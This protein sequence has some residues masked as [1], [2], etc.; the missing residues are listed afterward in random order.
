MTT[1]INMYRNEFLFAQAYLEKLLLDKYDKDELNALTQTIKEWR[2]YE[3]SGSASELLDSFVGPVLDSLQF[4]RQ[5][6]QSILGGAQLLPH[7]GAEQPVGVVLVVDPTSQITCTSKGLHWAVKL[8]RFMCSTGAGWG[9]L[10]DGETWRLYRK[11]ELAPY[12]TFLEVSLGAAIDKDNTNA[13]R[14]FHRFFTAEAFTVLDDNQPALETYR[15]ASIKVTQEIEK[16]L[17]SSMD[18]VLRNISMGFVQNEARTSFSQEERDEIFQNSVYLLYR[19][20]FILYTES[21][22]LLPVSNPIYQ[23]QYSLK[24]LTRVAIGHHFKRSADITGYDLWIRLRKLFIWIDEGHRATPE[25]DFEITEYDG[26]LFDTSKRPYLSEHL[27]NNEFLSE[28]LYQ[29]NCMD[30]PKKP[31]EHRWIDYRDL[32]VRHLGSLYES[33][34]EYKLYI[35]EQPMVASV[36]GDK[37]KYELQSSVQLKETDQGNLIPRG[38]VY[39]GQSAT[40]RKRTG[41]YYTP[42]DVVEYI[43][44]NTVSIG[45]ENL[46]MQ[47]QPELSNLQANVNNS[48]SDAERLRLQRYTDETVEQFI[49]Q[50]VFT[51]R[52]LDPAMGSGHFLVNAL[53]K[54]TNFAVDKLSETP[55]PN[56]ALDTSPV[57]W[58]RRVV[59]RCIFGVDLN[60]LA[61]ELAKLSLWLASASEG[62]PLSFLN[63]HLKTGNSLIGAKLSDLRALP[64]ANDNK[65][66]PTLPF[67]VDDTL[68]LVISEYNKISAHDSDAM[69]AVEDK[70]RRDKQIGQILTRIKD[71]ANVWV[72]TFYGNQVSQEQYS[73]LL[74][75]VN[76]NY[77]SD[78]WEYVATSKPYISKARD[79]ASSLRFFHWDLEFAEAFDQSSVQFD[80]VIANPPYVGTRAD[81]Y[82]LKRYTTSGCGDLYAWI[83]ERTGEIISARG[84][85]GTVVPLSV[86]FSRQMRP[87]RSVFLSWKANCYLSSYDIRPASLFGTP[88]S[89]NSQRATIAI[90]QNCGLTDPHIFTTN[91]IRWKSDERDLV[92]PNLHYTDVTELASANSFPKIGDAL[93]RE[94]WIRLSSVS[95][96]GADLCHSILSEGQNDATAE[97]FLIAPRAINYFLSA[98]PF[99]I[100][101]KKV[102]TLT[103]DSKY[104]RDLMGLL[105]NSNVFY[106][107]WRV[108]GDGFVINVDTISCFPVPEIPMEEV[109]SLADELWTVAPACRVSMTRGIEVPNY[110]FNKRMDI[111]LKIDEMI[112]R[113]VTHDLALPCGIFANSK[114]HSFLRPLDLSIVSAEMEDD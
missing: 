39:F 70:K 108:F 26:E 113:H 4:V 93:L 5:N 48:L 32:S 58:R 107:Y 16:H 22:G 23:D 101:R 87:L 15:Q 75:L 27:I 24:T 40:E 46:W 83:M 66:A 102:L 78:S 60:P 90:F 30:V 9:I 92:I 6:D 10:T 14:I 74:R 52:I 76:Q 36:S 53:Q 51:Y 77:Q 72:S 11:D 55:W 49:R 20:V 111:L 97:Y 109:S 3:K 91:L 19:V 17:K 13:L 84:N 37:V 61:T 29:L 50:Q 1:D 63:H 88:D 64:T 82:V 85:I 100:D 89:P 31:G 106:W 42:E 94:F 8:V 95:R 34:L 62:S 59:E 65:I 44:S 41:S 80:A 45:L 96:T 114:S 18:D 81:Q 103:F 112:I 98:F 7:Y 35:A 68:P 2:K 86:M 28:A 54:V 105:I 25:E 104:S 79:I 57:I 33:L 47:F 21:R 73:E 99:R 56:A 43:V 38:G 69:D 67:Y 110:N 12:D 71:L